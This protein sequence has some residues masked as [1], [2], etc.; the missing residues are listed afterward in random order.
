MQVISGNFDQ[1]RAF[2]PLLTGDYNGE[3]IALAH[4]QDCEERMLMCQSCDDVWVDIIPSTMPLHQ[5]E[6]EHCLQKGYVSAFIPRHLRMP[7]D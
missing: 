4:Y 3:I 2:P 1:P 6:C 7:P 5:L